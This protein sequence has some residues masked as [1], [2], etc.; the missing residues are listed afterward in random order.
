MVG[1]FNGERRAGLFFQPTM[2]GGTAA[3]VYTDE[4]GQFTRAL[5]RK[6]GMT[7]ISVLTGRCL[8]PTSTQGTLTGTD[9][10]TF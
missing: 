4:N 5:L 1:D 10:R 6:P 7:G 2:P 3:I 9:V 8:M